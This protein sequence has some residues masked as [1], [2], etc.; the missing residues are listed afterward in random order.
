MTLNTRSM[1]WLNQNRHRAY[2]MERDPWRSAVG[3]ESSLDC[4][5]LDAV[6]FDATDGAEGRRLETRRYDVRGDRTEIHFV[7][8]GAPFAV[9]LHGGEPSGRGSFESCRTS[10]EVD[11]SG[12]PACIS[13]VFSSHAYILENVGERT[14]AVSA[15]VLSTRIVRIPHGRGVDGVVTGGSSKVQGGGTVS[16]DVV[17]E[18]GYRTMPI[19]RNGQVFVRVGVGYGYDP[20]L[21]EKADESPSQCDELMFFFCGQNATGNKAGNVVIKGGR[22]VAVT[23]GGEYRVR[24]GTA[25]GAT[26][27]CI[28]I[29]ATTELLN[30]YRPGLLDSSSSGEG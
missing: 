2:P 20:C 27:P 22:G 14:V 23:Q 19:V 8:G 12:V 3:P 16:G 10:I 26:V 25:A 7:Y 30:I 24:T 21:Y 13:L 4:V 6:V 1:D 18:D 15:P 11:D 28:E 29:A 5:L 17:L 9:T